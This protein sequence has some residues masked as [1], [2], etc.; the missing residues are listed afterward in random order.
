[1][2]RQ[3]MLVTR[4]LVFKVVLAAFA[5]VRD[6]SRIEQYIPREYVV[7]ARPFYSA[8]IAE[9]GN[10]SVCSRPQTPGVQPRLE[11]RVPS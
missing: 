6:G 10:Y 8:L 11:Q 2:S 7:Q 5:F 4:G 3:Y 1:M 9:N